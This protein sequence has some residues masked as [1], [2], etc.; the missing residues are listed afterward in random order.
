M[1]GDRSRSPHESMQSRLRS[2]QADDRKYLTEMHRL[3]VAASLTLSTASSMC[4]TISNL[5]SLQSYTM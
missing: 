5:G 1:R 2:I 4:V 3:T